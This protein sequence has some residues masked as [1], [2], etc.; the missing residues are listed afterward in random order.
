MF[1]QDVSGDRDALIL[2]CPATA[3]WAA[4]SNTQT[5]SLQDG[6]SEATKT[7]FDKICQEEP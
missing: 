2:N 6:S 4:Y 3:S 1:A 7:S 5:Y